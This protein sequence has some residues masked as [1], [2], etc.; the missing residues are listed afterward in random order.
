[1]EF[2]FKWE[3]AN[4]TWAN[5]DFEIEPPARICSHII[6]DNGTELYISTIWQ[7]EYSLSDMFIHRE[8]PNDCV[9]ILPVTEIA[10]NEN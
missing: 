5:P 1:M 2:D 8:L 6:K 9:K 4:R 10:K 7:D 3:L